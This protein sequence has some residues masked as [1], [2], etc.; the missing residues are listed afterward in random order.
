MYSDLLLI[1]TTVS[2]F[3]SVLLALFLFS[4]KSPNKLSNYLFATYLLLTVIDVSGYFHHAH[5]NV[6]ANLAMLRNLFI[7]LQLPTL[8]LYVLSACY[9]DFRLKPIHLLHGL[10]FILVNLMFLPRFYLED[11]SGKAAFLSN[12]KEVFEVQFNHLLLH[13]QVFVY[14]L[15]IFVVISRARRLYLENNAGKKLQA[16]NWLFQ[17]AVAISLFYALALLKNILKFSEYDH[18]SYLFRVGLYL[19]QL[20]IIC[21][22]ML[23]SLKHPGLFRNVDSK[24]KL[25]SSMANE[26]VKMTREEDD[27]IQQLH[28][29]MLEEAPYLDPSISL[30]ELANKT[31]IAARELSV[32]IN[33]QIGQHFFDYINSYRIEKAKELLTDPSKKELTI[34]EILYE[35]G[36]NSKSS[37]NTAFK[38]HTATTPTLFRKKH[39]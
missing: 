2:I 32:L 36:F 35:V 25:A 27:R 24:L 15:M 5:T 16:Y 28:Q 17:L 19:F 8:Y 6:M 9:A 12:F 4:L 20:L 10:P 23:K 14:L 21:W 34:L 39:S 26:E 38:K 11:A 30:Q 7:F 33:H 31:G 3:V 18:A 29:Y 22:Y 13:I 1:V 37:F